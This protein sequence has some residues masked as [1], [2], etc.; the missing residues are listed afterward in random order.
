MK[1]QK[2]ILN[3]TNR[4]LV[5]VKEVTITKRKIFGLL[6]LASIVLQSGLGVHQWLE[7]RQLQQSQEKLSSLGL[8]QNDPM[9]DEPTSSLDDKP[10][11]ELPTEDSIPEETLITEK[12]YLFTYTPN[13]ASEFLQINSEYV[14]HVVIPETTINYPIAKAKDNEFY[15]NHNFFKEKDPLGAVFMDYRNIG[16]H[17]D[18]HAILYGHYTKNNQVFGELERYLEEEFLMNN[19]FITFMTPTGEKVYEIFSVH[20][21]PSETT[22][23]NTTFRDVSYEEFLQEL[24][25]QSIHEGLVTPSSEANLLSLI[26]CNYAIKDGRLFIHAIERTP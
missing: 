25:Q 24:S 23:I 2:K 10:I 16:M 20:V 4:D 22:Y 7:Q 12:P 5:F 14:G 1:K 3:I 11:T 21:S 6:L 13:P 9:K 8:P 19:R 26:T 15:L 17:H 18:R